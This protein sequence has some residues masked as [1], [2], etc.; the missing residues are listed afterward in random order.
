MRKHVLGVVLMLFSL[1]LNAQFRF[2][3]LRGKVF[4]AKD[5]LA[6]KATFEE[7]EQVT[8]AVDYYPIMAAKALTQN[9]RAEGVQFLARAIGSG[10]D[11]QR[12]QENHTEAFSMLSKVTVD[13]LLNYIHLS[14]AISFNWHDRQLLERIF[15]E[16]QVNAARHACDTNRRMLASSLRNLLNNYMRSNG[17]P[18]DCE[19]GYGMQM[20]SIRLIFDRSHLLYDVE[21]QQLDPMLY[22]AAENNEISMDLYA[23]LVDTYLYLKFGQMRYGSSF[24]GSDPEQLAYIKKHLDAINAERKAVGLS[25]IDIHAE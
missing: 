17:L 16:D 9:Y 5:Y 8:C 2:E 3:L 20:R 7:L 21:W 6:A 19:V 13:S 25:K 4:L 12:F 14:N 24:R 1:A 15:T 10:Y 23:S 22:R 18:N 11:M